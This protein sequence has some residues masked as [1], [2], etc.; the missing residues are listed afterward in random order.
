MTS[1]D[2]TSSHLRLSALYDRQKQN[3]SHPDAASAAPSGRCG[4]MAEERPWRGERCMQQTYVRQMCI[5]FV[6]F[7]CRK[8][9]DRG[10]HNMCSRRGACMHASTHT[11]TAILNVATAAPSISVAPSQLPIEFYG[12][13]SRSECSCCLIHL[14]SS[15]QSPTAR[16]LCNLPPPP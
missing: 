2:L 8:K 7:L 14:Y 12:S 6:L 5:A 3:L 9:R 15:L 13:P 10:A 4:G 11:A 1:L 16:H